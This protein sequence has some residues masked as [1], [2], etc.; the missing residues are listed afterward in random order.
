VTVRLVPAP[1]EV[2]PLLLP[3]CVAVAI[4][5]ALLTLPRGTSSRYALVGVAALTVLLTA[6]HYPLPLLAFVTVLGPFGVLVALPSAVLTLLALLEIVLLAAYMVVR[7][8]G[9]ASELA[10]LV[11]P[12]AVALTLWTGGHVYDVSL[13]GRALATLVALGLLA[14]AVPRLEVATTAIV[15]VLVSSTAGVA[16]ADDPSVT[17]AV[18]LT[19]AGAIVVASSLLGRSHRQLA[20][21]GGLL[22]AA[23]TWVRL[24]DVGVHAP[25]PY[26]LPTA[27]VLVLVGLDRL[28]R[29]PEADTM[30][31][32]LPG[33]VL[34]VV[35]TL[36]WALVDPVSTRAG[37]VGA[38]A[39]VLL[40]GGTGLRWTA[41]VLV[42]WLAGAALVLREL[43]PY[44]AQWPQWVLIGASGA[45]LFAAGITWEARL[46][47]L[48]QAAAYLG[49][50]R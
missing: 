48:R 3:V 36:L 17:L 30:P 38:A 26:T 4:L 15:S 43:A 46:R 16:A 7:R 20:W 45:V 14:I 49:R 6:A 32:L 35:P 31:A 42:G 25:E 21:P 39:L 13:G 10:G 18:H 5:A 1:S 9:R 24:Y 22:L 40:V 23:A 29:D 50:L 37:V 34:A 12:V 19:V 27:V 44:A 11:L 2:S 33:L 28:R 41:P 8:T 47:D